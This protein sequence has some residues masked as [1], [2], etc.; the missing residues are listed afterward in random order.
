MSQLQERAAARARQPTLTDTLTHE[1]LDASLQRDA[2]AAVEWAYFARVAE[3]EGFPEAARA[4]RE[5]A[6]QHTHAAQGHLDLLIRA[7]D[8]LTG[9]AMGDTR[10]NLAVAAQHEAAEGAVEGDRARTARN[11]GFH[12]IASWFESVGRMRGEHAAR[13]ERLLR[14]LEEG[15]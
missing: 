6:E 13:L 7:K 1:H 3:I 15:R 2:V 11:E 4:L 14:E 9:R 12:D 10:Q 8:P 5:L